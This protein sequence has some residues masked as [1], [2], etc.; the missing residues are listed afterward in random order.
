MAGGKG[1]RMG[2]PLEKPLLP[3]LGKP[4]ID[5]IAKAVESAETISE[6]FVVTSSNTPETERHCRSRGWRVL[7]TDA[8]GYHDD[9]RQAAYEAGLSG[10]ILTVP[11]DLPAVTGRFLDK[12]VVAFEESGKDFFAVFVPIEKRQSLGLSVD[13]TDEYCGKRYAVSGVNIVNGSK[14]QQ[15]GKIDT[16]AII[17]DDIEV[18]L[19]INTVGDLEIAQ[20]LVQ[21]MNR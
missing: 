4:L 2:L 20:R 1:K 17:T 12:V 3:F 7:Q 11:G 16:G 14:I 8:K 18:L 6:F 15:T 5:W 10:A 21:A 9:L 13:S 19:N